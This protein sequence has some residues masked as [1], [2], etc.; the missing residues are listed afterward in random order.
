MGTWETIID[1]VIYDAAIGPAK[2][3][4]NASVHYDVT[5]TYFASLQ[6]DR[7]NQTK[8]DEKG[9]FSLSV[10][11]HD[12]DSIRLVVTAPEFTPYEEKLVGID[13]VGGKSFSIGLTREVTET[14]DSP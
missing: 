14:I 6:T 8:T 2:P 13:L 11:V 12:T 9:Q 7:P 10:I 5:G 4:M 3:I 1:G